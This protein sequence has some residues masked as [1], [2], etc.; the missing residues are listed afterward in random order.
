MPGKAGAVVGP[1][2][3]WNLGSISSRSPLPMLPQ[4]HVFLLPPPK[5]T[6]WDCW[7]SHNLEATSQSRSKHQAEVDWEPLAET[8]LKGQT[9]HGVAAT[10]CMAVY[11]KPL[12]QNH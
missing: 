6:V 5:K 12:G 9:G 2:T 10:S 11:R 7:A 4:S 8:G 1:I 3:F